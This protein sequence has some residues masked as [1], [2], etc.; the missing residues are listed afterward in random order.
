MIKLRSTSEEQTKQLAVELAK[1]LKPGDIICLYGDLGAGKTTFVK[2]VARHFI[3]EESKVVSPTYV[4]L[5]I[6]DGD[7][8]VY[9]FDLYRLGDMNQINTLGYEEYFYGD[10]ISFIEWPERLG[11]SMPDEYLKINFEHC[12]DGARAIEITA[13]GEKYQKICDQIK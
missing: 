13:I 9:H 3:I 7:P 8:S 4:L 6:Y 10:G 11:E 5:N 12:S 1:S 2:G